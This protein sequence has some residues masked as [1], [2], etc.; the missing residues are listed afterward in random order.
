M[1]LPLPL[2]YFAEIAKSGS[3]RQASEALFVVPSAISRQIANLE[4]EFGAELFER[5]PRG[6]VLTAAGRLLLDY[7]TQSEVQGLLVR[8]AIDDLGNLRSGLVRLAIV[9][10]ASMSFMPDLL[11]GFAREH[12]NIAFQLSVCGT[13]QIV[14]S[15]VDHTVD[16]GLAFNVLNRDDV[17]LHGRISQPLQVICAPTHALAARSMVSISEL[18]DF[19][20]AVPDR[21]FGVR[22]LIDKAAEEAKVELRIA[23]EMNSLQAIK[24][25]VRRSDV[26]GFMPP[27]TFAHELEEGWLHA[28][29]LSERACEAATIDVVTSRQRKLPLAATAFLQYLLISVRTP[30]P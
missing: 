23:Y 15:V 8:S 25:I 16:I 20:A 18:I 6:M 24:S 21:T 29:A 26:I 22:Y 10:A 12:P 1:I 13:A 9:E 11:V 27:M 3:V 7:V 17:T 2:K 30:S 28:V 4:R 19:R 14:E 5:S